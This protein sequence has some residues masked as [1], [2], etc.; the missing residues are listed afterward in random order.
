MNKPSIVLWR[1]RTTV[2]LTCSLVALLIYSA[3]A[4]MVTTFQ[5]TV[6]VR[7][8]SGV[9]HL[10]VADDQAE[11]TQGLSG[12]ESLKADG[13][14]LMKFASDD[15]WRIWMKDMQVPL[16]I[17]WLNSSKQVVYIVKNAQPELS[18][19]TIFVPKE[20]ARYVVELPAGSVKNAGIR[21][22]SVASFDETDDGSLW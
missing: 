3:V 17:V 16:D 1:P 20:P 4:Y 13:G 7:L 5:P 14:L 19:D 15:T 10:R 18:T 6:E 9:Y 2:I 12:V 8:G 21:T 11:L 22:G